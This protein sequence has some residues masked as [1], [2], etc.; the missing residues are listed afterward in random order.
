MNVLQNALMTGLATQ[1]LEQTAPALPILTGDV[2][3]LSTYGKGMYSGA[4]SW[5]N[6]SLTANFIREQDAPY[7]VTEYGTV[8]VIEEPRPVVVLI[9]TEASKVSFNHTAFK[10]AEVQ[11]TIIDWYTAQL[12]AKVQAWDER[13]ANVLLYGVPSIG[14][15]G[16]LQ[17][18]GIPS[19]ASTVNLST[20]PI[21]QVI[22]EI[23]RICLTPAKNS[24]YIYKPSMVALPSDLFDILNTRSFSAT[25]ATTETVLDVII[26]RLKTSAGYNK[27][28]DPEW[29]FTAVPQFGASKLM[30]V[31]PDDANLIGGGIWD[32]QEF[33]SPDNSESARGSSQEFM[34]SSHSG[35]FCGIV[36][37][38]PN[39]GLVVTLT[40]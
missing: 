33:Y 35:G 19:I 11:G 12:K 27:A 9:H 16:L 24:I 28:G 23:I 14:V 32:L 25:G 20:A 15:P 17:G 8:Q 10:K 40:Y 4:I 7:L 22:N 31:L 34:A 1:V 29:K 36:A 3:A 18:S 6:Y 21:D 38:R 37:K 39:S 2:V 30:T 26:Q 5:T 13:C